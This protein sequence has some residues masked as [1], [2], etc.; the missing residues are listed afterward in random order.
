MD[1][2]NSHYGEVVDALRKEGHWVVFRSASSPTFGP[3]EWIF[4]YVDKFLQ[5]HSAQVH[6]RNLKSWI[7][8]A[9]DTI[10]CYD[11]MSYMAAAHFFVPGPPYNP[12]FGEQG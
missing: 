1:R 3:V 4:N 9:L 5:Q 2:L 6:P 10:S 11:V 8:M 12:Y 7:T